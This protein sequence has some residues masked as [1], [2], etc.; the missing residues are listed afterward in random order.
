MPSASPHRVPANGSVQPESARRPAM[1]RPLRPGPDHA[2][3]TGA[4]ER[5]GLATALFEMRSEQTFT[6]Q[7]SCSAASRGRWCRRSRGS[8]SA[9]CPAPSSAGCAGRVIIAAGVAGAVTSWNALPAEPESRAAGWR[10]RSATA[11][12]GWPAPGSRRTPGQ[13]RLVPPMTVDGVPW[14]T[15]RNPVSGSA[16]AATSGT[17]RI[18]VGAVE[19]GQRL[20]G[21]AAAGRAAR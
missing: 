11:G 13:A 3:V 7:Q 1:C 12:A 15:I 8:R 16:T 14:K 4:G 5:R 9:T 2:P 6:Q 17:T 21:T 18:G 10:S 19:V 20:V